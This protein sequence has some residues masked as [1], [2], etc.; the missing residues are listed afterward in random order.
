MKTIVALSDTHGNVSAMEKICQIMKENDFVFHLGDFYKDAFLFKRDLGD[1]LYCVAG[2]CDGGGD[3]LF[4]QIEELKVMLTHGDRYGVKDGIDRLYYK[5][6]ELG[7]NVVFYGHTHCADITVYDGITFINSGCM[8]NCFD[9]S[10]CYAVINKDKIVA[11]IVKI[12]G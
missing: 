3:D 8:K 10:Y 9:Q 1:K 4:L 11:K 6:K 12:N 5:A 2:N 7:V